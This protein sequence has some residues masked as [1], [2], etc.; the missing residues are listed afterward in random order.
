MDNIQKGA[1]LA[2]V[3]V[4]VAISVLFIF[5][6]NSESAKV[7]AEEQAREE[8]ETMCTDWYNSLMDRSAVYEGRQD[9]LGGT[10]DLGGDLAVLKNE[11][12]LDSDRYNAE[13]TDTETHHYEDNL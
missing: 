5:T 7:E 12:N 4:A 11:L 8:F 3:A 13:C 1:L 10:F 9:S 6:V 2:L